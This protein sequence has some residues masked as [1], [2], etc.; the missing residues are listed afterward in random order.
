VKTPA[1][2]PSP[3]HTM[4]QQS[5]DIAEAFSRTAGKYDRFAEDHP[6]LARMRG[7]VYTHLLRYLKPGARLLEL[8]A[9]TGTDA[10]Y[11][12]QQGFTVHSTDI[13]AGMLSLL[14]QKIERLGLGDRLT[15]QECSF[16]ELDGVQGGPFE[17]VFSNLGGLNCIPDLRLVTRQ[18]P[19]LLRPGGLIT[20]VLMPPICPWEL[21]Y[22]F[23]GN[24][25][26]AFRRLS[27]GGTPTH[28]EGIYFKTYYFTPREVIAAFGPAFST[29]A[30]EGLSVFAPPAESKN[31]AWRRP[32]LYRTLCRLDDQL[33]QRVPF[34][35]W[36]DFFI[37]SMR[38][39]P[40]TAMKTRTETAD[41]H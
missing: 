14:H 33:A 6:N 10:I 1:N 9:G 17:A 23:T 13:A 36:G 31:L 7:K 40:L 16:T 3:G 34:C 37:L 24:F 28:L 11:L 35:G 29:L 38:Y 18:I 15:V 21:V 22:A 20:V 2:F 5:G 30:V 4:E 25:R 32:R 41:K 8:N 19:G 39:K 26:F 12:A 27:R